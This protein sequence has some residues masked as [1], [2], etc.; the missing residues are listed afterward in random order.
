VKVARRP[1]AV[2]GRA[3]FTLLELLVS[4]T[5]FMLVSGAVVTT[6]ALSTALNRTNRETALAVR[7]AQS[8]LE[9]L[10]GVEEFEEIYARYNATSD[11]DPAAG[12]SPGQGFAVAGLSAR[13]DDADGFVGALEF[14]G[15]GKELLEDGEDAELGLPRDLDGDGLVDAA[16]HAGDYRILP[17]RVVVEWSGQN[18]AR[19][20]ELVTVLTEM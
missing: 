8:L 16:D 9:E 14:P 18:G 3:A 19:T 1:R 4:A 11:D 2:A 15:T 7:A 13:S 5:I 6:L 10:K 12:S 20:L 17:V